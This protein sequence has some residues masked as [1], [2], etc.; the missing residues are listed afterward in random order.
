M[1]DSTLRF[2]PYQPAVDPSFWQELA[3]KKLDEWQLRTDT[4]AGTIFS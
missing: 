1:A 2:V 3:R 4:K